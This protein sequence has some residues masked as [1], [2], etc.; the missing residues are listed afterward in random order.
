MQLKEQLSAAAACILIRQNCF[1][2][3]LLVEQMCNFENDIA[4]M[5]EFRKDDEVASDLLWRKRGSSKSAVW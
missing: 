1:F 3:S 4:G 2:G 5:K